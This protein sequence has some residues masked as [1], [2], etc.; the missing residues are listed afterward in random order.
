MAWSRPRPA[1]TDTT[2]RSSASGSERRSVS[3][4]LATFFSRKKRGRIQPAAQPNTI[5]ATLHDRVGGHVDLQHQAHTTS[6]TRVV[7]DAHAVKHRQRRFPS[8]IPPA[9]RLVFRVAIS[10][11]EEGTLRA[12]LVQQPPP[13]CW[14]AARPWS[15]MRPPAAFVRDHRRARAVSENAR[16]GS[17][18][19]SPTQ[20]QPGHQHQEQ[21]K[22]QIDSGSAMSHLDVDDL[23]DEE[24]AQDLGD[25]GAADHPSC[26]PGPPPCLA[27]SRA[28]PPAGPP[29]WRSAAASEWWRSGGRARWP[30]SPGP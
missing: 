20:R 9:I 7:R 30:P 21:R 29:W 28:P 23:L 1:S 10:A 18:C 12:D 17:T 3:C 11:S 22:S 26:R 5:S 27:G 15:T 4:R 19:G 16:A 6:I 2:S 24:I 13:S 14:P 25:H 8:G